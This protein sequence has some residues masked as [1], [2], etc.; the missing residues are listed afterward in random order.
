MVNKIIISVLAAVFTLTLFP[1]LFFGIYSLI[2]SADMQKLSTVTIMTTMFMGIAY[3]ATALFGSY[4]AIQNINLPKKSYLYFLL[5]VSVLL[6]GI[7]IQRL[8]A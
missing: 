2:N 5:P 7:L 6:V 4:K 3:A 8:G 1:L